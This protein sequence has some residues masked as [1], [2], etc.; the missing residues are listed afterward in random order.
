MYIFIH[1]ENDWILR[2]V[3][4]LERKECLKLITYAKDCGC[5]IPPYF[6]WLIFIHLH[7]VYLK[8]KHTPHLHVQS[9]K[10]KIKH[11][12]RRRRNDTKSSLKSDCSSKVLLIN[13]ES[14]MGVCVH[15]FERHRVNSSDSLKL[16]ESS[17]A[18]MNK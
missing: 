15:L 18:E 2:F 13:N 10:T 12:R 1:A 17:H 8:C 3:M 11:R 7:C 6:F 4:H 9:K 14:C 5:H 16:R